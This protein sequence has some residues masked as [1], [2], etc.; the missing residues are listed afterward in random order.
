[1][2]IKYKIYKKQEAYKSF[3]DI[4]ITITNHGY[5][6]IT[7]SPHDFYFNINQV[8]TYPPWIVNPDLIGE[9]DV[10]LFDGGTT[11]ITFHF[12]ELPED[13][14]SIKLGITKELKGKYNITITHPPKIEIKDGEPTWHITKGTEYYDDGTV[15]DVWINITY[16]DVRNRTEWVRFTVVDASNKNRIF[17]SINITENTSSVLVT[18]HPLDNMSLSEL[19]KTRF[20]VIMNSSLSE[21]QD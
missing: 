21:N 3:D 5:D 15:K 17:Y 1:M 10:T 16:N 2:E 7:V 6:E 9:N 8:K 12:F 18:Y 11:I 14:Q 13:L 20:S 19:K 4:V